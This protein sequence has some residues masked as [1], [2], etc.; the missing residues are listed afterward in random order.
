MARV[1]KMSNT[2]QT[3]GRKT[4]GNGLKPLDTATNNESKAYKSAIKA[5]EMT[6]R[7]LFPEHYQEKEKAKRG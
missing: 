3:K 6:N 5:F 7:R 2:K 4:N 1:K